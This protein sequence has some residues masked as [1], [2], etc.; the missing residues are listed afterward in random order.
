MKDY[1]LWLLAHL[2]FFSGNKEEIKVFI[3][4][5]PLDK[6]SKT[7]HRHITQVKQLSVLFA[8][9]DAWR[10]LRNLYKEPRNHQNV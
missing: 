1:A 9:S 7:P 2:F 8:V 6:S 10:E 5:I 3:L 4:S